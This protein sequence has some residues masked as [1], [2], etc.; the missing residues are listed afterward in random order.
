M[1]LFL[2][3]SAEANI[4]AALADTRVVILNGARQVGK[5]TVVQAATKKLRNVLMRTLDRPTDLAA[6]KQDPEGFVEH[7]GL[8]V[9]DEI[10]RA[11]QIILP[12]K[13]QVDQRSK[14]GQF[15]LTG[16]A[17]ILGLKDLPDALVGRS[18]TIELW[19][20]SQ[21]EIQGEGKQKKHFAEELFGD[22]I[23]FRGAGIA[24]RDDY[25]MRALRGGFPEAT[26]RVGSR[27]DRFFESYVRDLIDRD[28]VQLS[29]IERRADLL[30]LIQLLAS[31][32]AT[33]LKIEE[34]SSTLGVPARTLERYVALLEQ[35][36]LI[37]RIPA[38]SSSRTSRAVRMQKLMVVDSGIASFLNG[39]T[40]R[41]LQR[42]PSLIGPLLEN[43]ALSELAR[44]L[45]WSELPITL[46]HYRTRDGEE[47]DGLLEANDGRL[48][49]IEVKA[50]STVTEVDFR[51]L[52]HLKK[53]T[54]NAFHL[55]IVLYTGDRV[56][57]FGPRMRA[58]PLDALW[59]R[60]R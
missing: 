57:P 1:S 8:M 38:W 23:V 47:V 46:F 55:G 34:L 21:R 12:I 50:S 42:E 16:S 36:F 59:T 53:R 35:V 41:K 22:A 52:N 45:T 6:A 28:V 18:E 27:R 48:V 32:Q 31:R 17:R 14:P 15:L 37:K 13:A 49:G 24:K 11:P 56:L 40:E 58:I 9:I 30:R 54:G 3:R 10:Q 33:L 60:R 43:F 20:F 44:Q 29:E 4:A 19:P 7:D 51:H 26:K 25:V 2:P 39:C 5:S